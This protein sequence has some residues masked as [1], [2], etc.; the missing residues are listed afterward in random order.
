MSAPDVWDDWAVHQYEK[1]T[2]G[3]YQCVK[4]QQS[5]EHGIHDY[6]KVRTIAAQHYATPSSEPVRGNKL[7]RMLERIGQLEIAGREYE[8]RIAALERE[9]TE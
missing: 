3:N 5:L 9:L 8:K 1:S 6:N 4:C 2:A 7:D